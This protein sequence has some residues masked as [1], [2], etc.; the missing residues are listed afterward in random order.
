MNT[1]SCTEIR[2]RLQDYLDGTL[3]RKA[4]MALFLHVRE[5]EGCSRQLAEMER[6][7]GR[8]GSLAPVEP[9]ADFDRRIL[10]SVPYAA[11]RAMEPLRRERMPVILEEE[12][13]PAFVRARGTRAVGGLVAVLTAIGLATDTLT[14][15]WAALAA[16][17][18]LPEA[19]IR[20]QGASR[21][22]YAG[23]M[24]RSTSR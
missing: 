7:F 2:A 8:L 4:S 21:R 3:P 1:P 23:V 24:Q 9:P 20:L 6:L 18:V 14:G 19:L 13:L 15:G 10:E 17:G 12:A 22:I 5:C 16:V 11:Y